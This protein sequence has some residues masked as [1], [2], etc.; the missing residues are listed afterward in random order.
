ME[1]FWPHP[2]APYGTRRWLADEASG[3]FLAP[4]DGPQPSEVDRA[5]CRFR[6][7]WA[8]DGSKE[9]VAKIFRWIDE[10]GASYRAIAERLNEQEV[11]P[12]SGEAEGEWLGT[13]V[14]RLARNPIYRGDAVL[15]RTVSDEEP[16]P[17]DEASRDPDEG[18]PI[19]YRNF[20]PGEP[21][22]SR[23]R[24]ASVQAIVEQRNEQ[25]HGRG[26]KAKYLLSGILRCGH[27]GGPFTGHTSTRQEQTRRTYYRH[28]HRRECP[29]TDRSYLRTSTIDEAVLGQLFAGLGED[30][31]ERVEHE[32][33]RLRGQDRY[34]ERKQRLS[35]LGDG[36]Q[37]DREALQQ[38]QTEVAYAS[39]EERREAIRR[40][41]EA[42]E[43]RLE[44]KKRAR[45]E[46]QAEAERA[47]ELARRRDDLED[48][49]TDKVELLRGASPERRKSILQTLL[50]EVRVFPDQKRLEIVS[51]AL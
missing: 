23:E 43:D 4:A 26:P 20:M 6:L 32:L 27:C 8:T 39:T 38:L 34:D 18:R 15:N 11:V 2:T 16:V 22:V 19:L 36:I 24:F 48:L 30:F 10:E 14:A 50:D 47:D 25:G 29:E 3:E 7:K 31:D 44:Q 1:G 17:A 13:S 28:D 41:I 46:L 5:S 51:R 49:L 35:E 37:E 12:P 21:P 33:A 42:V 40:S 45:Q 9:V